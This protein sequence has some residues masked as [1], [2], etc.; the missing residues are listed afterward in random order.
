[1]IRRVQQFGLSPDRSFERAPHDHGQQAE[2]FDP[3]SPVPRLVDLVRE[4]YDGPY[5][6]RAVSA[7]VNSVGNDDSDVLAPRSALELL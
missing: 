1:M 3:S 2:W 7:G 4:P 6:R 5:E